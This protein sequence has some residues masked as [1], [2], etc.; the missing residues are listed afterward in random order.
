M[1]VE[2]S[3]ESCDE[4]SSI[5]GRVWK[6]SQ[7]PLGSRLVQAALERADSEEQR[8]LLAHELSGHVLR[9]MRCPHGNHVL[10]KIVD[11]ME[12]PESLQ[13]IVDAFTHRNR[14]VVQAAK[15]RYGCRIVQRLLKA[16]PPAQVSEITQ[17][18]VEAASTLACHMYGHYV[19]QHLLQF[20]TEDQKHQLVRCIEQNA[21]DIGHST[22]G[23]SVLMT[24]LTHAATEDKAWIA[25]AFAK[26]PQVLLFSAQ[27]RCGHAGVLAMMSVLQD[28]GD[29]HIRANL[30][31]RLDTLRES[32]FGRVIAK[33]LDEA[34][35]K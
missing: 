31:Q 19:V 33:K 30:A 12:Q 10:Q 20:G 18:L 15:H 23:G 27:D 17:T 35:A 5:V 26:D 29:Q 9:T 6:L 8:C 2:D 24:A 13:F 7:D 25:R 16:C 34:D 3:E 21:V 28:R 1:H 14:L 22:V 11:T 4:D 32:R